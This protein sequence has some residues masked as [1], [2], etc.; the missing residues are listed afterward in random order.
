MAAPKKP[1]TARQKVYKKSKAAAAKAEAEATAAMSPA[2]RAAKAPKLSKRQKAARAKRRMSKPDLAH[3]E[4]MRAAKLKKHE[5]EKKVQVTLKTFHIVNGHRYGPG[6]TWVPQALTL[7]LLEQD[8]RALEVESNLY[9][10]NSHILLPRGASMQVATPNFEQ[11][12]AGVNPPIY[13]VVSGR[14]VSDVGQ[15]PR[16]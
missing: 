12:W 11:I 5:D 7:T 16:F 4:A 14:G 3:M 6:M 1:L 9:V 15:G 2:R 10:T 13:D 8:R